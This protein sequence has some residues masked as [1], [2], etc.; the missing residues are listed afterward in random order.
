MRKLLTGHTSAETAF[1]QPDYPYGRELRCKRRVWIETKKGQGQRFVYQT[2]NPKA[3]PSR[4]EVW[5]KPHASTYSTVKVMYLDESNGHVEV[6]GLSL[7]SYDDKIEAFV[8]QYGEEA[9]CVDPWIA[10]ALPYMRKVA[11]K[12][13]KPA[14]A[15]QS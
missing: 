6:D 8:S 3:D 2:T 15:A 4:G 10:R 5:N 13:E 7:Y 9:L 11:C 12:R 14:Q 1:V